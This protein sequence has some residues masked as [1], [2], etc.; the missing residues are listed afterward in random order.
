MITHRG[1]SAYFYRYTRANG[2]VR[3]VYVAS[4]E[5]ALEAQARIDEPRL[6]LKEQRDRAALDERQHAEALGPTAKLSELINALV[7]A[8]LI[9]R[10]YRLHARG[11]WR[12]KRR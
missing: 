10:G 5:A 2:Q 7:K 9:R 4:G 11:E 3:R 1:Q 8:T 12:L 6:A